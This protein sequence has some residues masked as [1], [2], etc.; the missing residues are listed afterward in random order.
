MYKKQTA[1]NQK[2]RCYWVCCCFFVSG[3]GVDPDNRKKITRG[4]KMFLSAHSQ[5]EKGRT[6]WQHR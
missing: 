6:K 3:R 5:N 1:T 2:S 4:G